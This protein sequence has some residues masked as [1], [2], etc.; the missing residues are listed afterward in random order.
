MN[1]KT[2]IEQQNHSPFFRRSC[3]CIGLAL[4]GEEYLLVD[5]CDA[6][7]E[8]PAPQFY[9]R[10][11]FCA[12]GDQTYEWLDREQTE[13]WVKSIGRCVCYGH[14]FA[15]MARAVQTLNQIKEP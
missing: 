12:E 14:A 8:E 3:G 4:G 11:Q 6:R 7:H 15:D 5:A 9:G 2:A 1:A 10:R 13:K